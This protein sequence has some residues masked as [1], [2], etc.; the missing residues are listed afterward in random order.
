M[1]RL[2]TI[3]IDSRRCSPIS[4]CTCTARAHNYE[5]YNTMG[6]HI[7]ESLGVKGVRFAVWAPNAEVVCVVGDFNH[8]DTRRHPMRLRNGGIWEI[9]IP[10]IGAGT[11]YK[12]Y[13]RSRHLGYRQLKAD[14]VRVRVRGAAEIGFGR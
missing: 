1:S 5:S 7:V 3:R 13:M 10:G 6:A 11:P 2:R 14:P 9:F 8:W 4:I 12:Y